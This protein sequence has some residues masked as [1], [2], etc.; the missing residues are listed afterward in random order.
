M[1]PTTNNGAK[2]QPAVQLG[3]PAIAAAFVHAWNGVICRVRRLDSES[4]ADICRFRT[5]SR[6]LRT[7][8]C[9]KSDE[10]TLVPTSLVVS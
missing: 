6:T 9:D 7:C 10:E 2:L 8:Y 1:R 4:A 5:R 3:R